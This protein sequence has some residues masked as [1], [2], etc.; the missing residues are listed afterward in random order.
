MSS[1]ESD[2]DQEIE[3]AV[4]GAVRELGGSVSAEHGIG[5]DKL[6]WLRYS[7]NGSEIKLMQSIR[8]LIDPNG[9]MNPGRT[10]PMEQ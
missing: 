8:E 4:Y 6:P 9:I 3:I 5:S 7:R 2:L 10:I 1:A